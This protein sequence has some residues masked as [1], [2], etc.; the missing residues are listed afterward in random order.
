MSYAYNFLFPNGRPWRS[1][2]CDLQGAQHN[3]FLSLDSCFFFFSFD[4]NI[5]LHTVASVGVTRC[6]TQMCPIHTHITIVTV[7]RR[8]KKSAFITDYSVFNE[9]A[10]IPPEPSTGFFGDD[11]LSGRQKDFW[12]SAN[13]AVLLLASLLW[14]PHALRTLIW[15]TGEWN[16]WFYSDVYSWHCLQ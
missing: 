13:H 5:I 9:A 3:V 15:K 11:W 12:T 6:C 16:T 2:D 4:K 8:T 14:H 1:A 10:T 7:I